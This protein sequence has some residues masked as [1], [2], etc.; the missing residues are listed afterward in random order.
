MYYDQNN[1]LITTKKSNKVSRD[2]MFSKQEYFWKP[3]FTSFTVCWREQKWRHIYI[4]K[5]V[6][7]KSDV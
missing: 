4:R 1:D 6:I 5:T 7:C 3:A 2:K